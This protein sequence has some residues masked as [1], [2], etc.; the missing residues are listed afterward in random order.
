MVRKCGRACAFT[1]VK[2]RKP[3][4]EFVSTNGIAADHKHGNFDNTV[5]KTHIEFNVLL[6]VLRY[7]FAIR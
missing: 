6:T 5:N 7:N 3:F 1:N 2:Q 4:Y